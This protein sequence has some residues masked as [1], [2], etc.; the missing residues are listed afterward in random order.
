MSN[1]QDSGRFVARQTV[2]LAAVV[3]WLMHYGVGGARYFISAELD[4]LVSMREPRFVS[5][6]REHDRRCMASLHFYECGT[7]I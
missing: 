1:R 3:G 6:R 2:L 7:I 4:W 5:C